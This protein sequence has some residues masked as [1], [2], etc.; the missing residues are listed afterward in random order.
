MQKV[1]AALHRLLQFAALSTAAFAMS[2]NPS[3]DYRSLSA[4]LRNGFLTAPPAGGMLAGPPAAN[5]FA[6]QN[7][8]GT[9]LNMLTLLH[10]AIPARPWC[11]RRAP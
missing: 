5:I 11:S 10:R 9:R 2:I 1:A 3:H 4:C 7:G 8:S 6:A